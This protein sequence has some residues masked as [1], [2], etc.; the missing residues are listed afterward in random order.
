MFSGRRPDVNLD[1]LT[2]PQ[3][4]RLLASMLRRHKAVAVLIDALEGA[5]AAGCD[6]S[7]MQCL[8]CGAGCT[9]PAPASRMRAG[10]LGLRYGVRSAALVPAAG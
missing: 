9:G 7:Y 3:V 5:R 2:P 8:G 6:L 10:R 4:D 1:D